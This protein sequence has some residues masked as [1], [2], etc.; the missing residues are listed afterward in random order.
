MGTT[1]FGVAGNDFYLC[2]RALR[3]LAQAAWAAGFVLLTLVLTV[4]IIARAILSKN[5]HVAR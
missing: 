1:H 5:K 2:H 3:R 4:N